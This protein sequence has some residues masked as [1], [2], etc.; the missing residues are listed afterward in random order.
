[1]NH[2]AK[3]GYNEFVLALGYKADVVKTIFLITPPNS[4]F[5]VSLKTG[6]IEWH[7]RG[8]QDWKVTLVDTG[9]HSMT[10][11]RLGRLKEMLAEDTLC[12]PMV[13]D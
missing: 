4:D 8:E 12:L 13:M 10:G 2:Y 9:L 11:G 5:T 7:N 1:M 3:Y 6:E